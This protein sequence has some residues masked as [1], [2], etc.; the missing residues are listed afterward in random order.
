MDNLVLYDALTFSSKLHSTQDIIELLGLTSCPWET[1]KGYYGYRDRLYFNCI[2]IHFNG[3]DDMGICVEMTGQ[4]CRAFEEYGTG[5]YENLFD[6]LLYHDKQMNLTRLD[7]AFDD[8]S[9]ILDIY[10]LAEDTRKQ[11]FVSRFVDWKI[12]EGNKGITVNHGSNKSE[13][14]LRIY[15]KAAERHLDDGSHWIRVEL[16]L[17]RDRALSFI[18]SAGSIGD[19]F[20][21]VLLNYVRY[22]EEDEFDT[23]KWRW[24][25]LPYWSDLVGTVACISLYVKPGTD[26]NIDRLEHFVFRQAGNAIDTYIQIKGEDAFKQNL[27][28]RGTMK[29][30][31]YERLKNQY[32]V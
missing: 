24:C 28:K 2:S 32:G 3:S 8:H 31:K 19:R 30:P 15:D 14:F 9:G 20:C 18:K 10:R 11:C 6:L 27:Q 13:I 25:L 23:N 12:E 4:G 21:G 7:V 22:V 16:Q 29:N 5:D 26:Y 17:R 1:I